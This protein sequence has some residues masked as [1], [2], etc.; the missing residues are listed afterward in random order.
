MLT[1]KIFILYYL[2]HR[3][4]IWP[5]LN[6]EENLS[7]IIWNIILMQC[8]RNKSVHVNRRNMQLLLH[9]KIK[10]LMRS[11]SLKSFVI[12]RCFQDPLFHMVESCAS[13]SKNEAKSN[14]Y[15]GESKFTIVRISL[16]IKSTSENMSS[17]E[18]EFH[19]MPNI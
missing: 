9:C 19:I 8:Y 5:D 6:K 13:L 14:K 10:I 3:I 12:V 15:Y 7:Y 18:V 17:P 4:I 16:F 2:K 1:F 11:K